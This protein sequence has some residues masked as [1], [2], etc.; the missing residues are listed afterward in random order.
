M[1][2]LSKELEIILLVLFPL[3]LFVKV[4]SIFI[5]INSIYLIYLAI[6]LSFLRAIYFMRFLKINIISSSIL[7]LGFLVYGILHSD[8]HYS[9][10][11]LVKYFILFCLVNLVNILNF[12]YQ[13]FVV[14]NKYVVI[15]TIYIVISILMTIEYIPYICYSLEI[16][17]YFIFIVIYIFSRN[18]V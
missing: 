9:D 17:S 7:F 12:I 10:L 3:F 13:L 8:Y 4:I 2:K 6:L 1:I 5:E 18:E 15:L 11:A 16:L 14:N